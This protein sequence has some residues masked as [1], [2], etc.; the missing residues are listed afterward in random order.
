MRKVVAYGDLESLA[1]SEFYQTI[2]NDIHIAESANMSD[3]LLNDKKLF[4]HVHLFRD[5]LSS[6]VPDW[7]KEGQRIRCLTLISKCIRI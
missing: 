6:L 1:S 7:S 3:L 2:R 4:P 5:F